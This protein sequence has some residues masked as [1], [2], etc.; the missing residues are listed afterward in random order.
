MDNKSIER[1]GKN[2]NHNNMEDRRCHRVCCEQTA[3]VNNNIW[4]MYVRHKVGTLKTCK[5]HYDLIQNMTQNLFMTLAE[6][7][8][9][10]QRCLEETWE[11]HWE[12]NMKIEDLERMFNKAI[13]GLRVISFLRNEMKPELMLQENYQLFEEVYETIY[14]NTGNIKHN[15][16]L[17]Q[18]NR[19]RH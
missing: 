13:K 12:N 9:I 14:L 8:Y 11:E 1:R 2:R 6:F 7:W 10:Y 16:M 4:I 3:V 18:R 5:K 19:V 17:K 15:I